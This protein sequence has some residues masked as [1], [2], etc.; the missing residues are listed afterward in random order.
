[1]TAIAGMIALA[2]MFTACAPMTL[3]TRTVQFKS[4]VNACSLLKSGHGLFLFADHGALENPDILFSPIWQNARQGENTTILK[5]P[6]SQHVKTALTNK[7]T[8]R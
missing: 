7:S 3:A 1:M 8:I 6:I 2:A 5:Q 4:L